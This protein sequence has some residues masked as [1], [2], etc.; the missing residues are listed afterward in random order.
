M[1]IIK[2]VQNVPQ[3][4]SFPANNSPFG[5]EVQGQFGL[6]YMYGT[7]Q[8]LVYADPPLHAELQA[9]APGATVTILKTQESFQTASGETRRKNVWR[10]TTSG[11]GAVA[12]PL[13]SQGHSA[14]TG[15]TRSSGD[16]GAM[17][18]LLSACMRSVENIAPDTYGPTERQASAISLFIGCQQK[19]VKAP[20]VDPTPYAIP[21]NPADDLDSLPF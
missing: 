14:P 4:V 10:V 21:T 15:N 16:F 2:F 1:A 8:G 3:V 18:E 11:Q 12:P 19:N 13:P 7:D 5:E 9:Y 20:E 6:Q 17:V